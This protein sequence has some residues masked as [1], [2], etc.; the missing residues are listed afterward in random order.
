MRNLLRLFFPMQDDPPA[1]PPPDSD[2][3][4]RSPEGRPDWCPEKFFDPD[5]GVRSEQLAKGYTELEGKMR[6][7]E[8]D[9]RASILED[10]KSQAPESYEMLDLTGV[11]GLEVPDDVELTLTAEDPMVDWF[12]G[13]AKE[14]GLTQEQVNAAIT[15]YVKTELAAM[16]SMQDELGKL[17]DHGQDRL[18]R[19]NAA[20][21]DRLEK[22]EL[23]ALKPLLASAETIAALEK[24]LAVPGPGNFDS[25]GP[26]EAMSLEEIRQLQA[27]DDYWDNP[28][29]QKKVADAYA[30]LYKNA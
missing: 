3:P 8:E 1:D 25:D 13:F 7:K 19:V 26:G 6:T 20:L 23:A 12:F 22:N 10:I 15:G 5:L 21:E 14:Q 29:L 28:V 24:I 4:S 11:E 9:L 27:R 2:P 30:R 16:P 18:L 17:G